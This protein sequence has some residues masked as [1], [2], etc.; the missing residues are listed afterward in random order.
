[1]NKSHPKLLSSKESKYHLKK[2]EKTII[3]QKI[4]F[5]KDNYTDNLWKEND[6]YKY[7]IEDLEIDHVNV[8][9]VIDFSIQMPSSKPR[10]KATTKKVLQLGCNQFKITDFWNDDAFDDKKYCEWFGND[11]EN[12]SKYSFVVNEKKGHGKYTGKNYQFKNEKD[13]EI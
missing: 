7:Y 8:G 2:L 5:L 13:E 11:V 10:L 4:Q 3:K 6:V 9:D 1:M 12:V